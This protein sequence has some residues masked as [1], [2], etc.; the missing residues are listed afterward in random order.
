MLR[1]GP[2][3]IVKAWTAP[4]HLLTSIMLAFNDRDFLE[5][6]VSSY[7]KW[8]GVDPDD[9]EFV[10]WDNGPPDPASRW[11][12][13]NL[14]NEC[15]GY[16]T[17]SG[18]GENVGI[19]AALNR[20]LE[21]TDSEFFFKFD[22][23]LELLPQTLPALLIAYVT[24]LSQGYPIAVLSAD[25]L[26]VGKSES[27]YRE[28]QL[29]PGMTLQEAPCVGGGCVLIHRSRFED[30]GVFREDRLYG[31]EDGDFAMRAMGK[32]YVNAYLKGAYQISKCRGPGANASYDQWKL[33]YYFGRVDKGW[34][35]K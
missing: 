18:F 22:D 30:I 3:D 1:G 35:E 12:L 10:I 25:V 34:G 31:V 11:Y 15:P 16:V 19:G 2:M 33:D 5:S 29:M 32:G 28:Y 26:G 20:T 17:F 14:K 4:K 13:E 9:Q 21:A 7:I 8:N 6:A 24:A 27:V 23:D